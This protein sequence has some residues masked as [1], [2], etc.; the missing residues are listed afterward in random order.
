M[1][2]TPSTGA[3]Y[4]FLSSAQLSFRADIRGIGAQGIVTPGAQCIVKP[5]EQ[6]S[7]SVLEIN[8]HCA[9]YS[10]FHFCTICTL[11]KLS[12]SVISD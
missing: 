9:L 3:S 6:Y 5:R 12:C 8:K 4:E 10:S 2:A 1:P 7:Q 11:Y